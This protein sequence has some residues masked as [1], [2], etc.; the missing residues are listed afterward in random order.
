MKMKLHSVRPIIS[1][2]NGGITFCILVSK[3][4]VTS[5]VCTNVRMVVFFLGLA[6]VW[7]ENRC[8][9]TVTKFLSSL[10]EET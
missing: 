5:E 10:G 3:I 6:F 2:S 8:S 7:C 9:A 1:V 4:L